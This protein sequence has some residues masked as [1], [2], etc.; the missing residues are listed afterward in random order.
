M[1]KY[2]YCQTWLTCLVVPSSSPGKIIE[3]Y[4]SQY[5]MWKK[6]SESIW[7]FANYIVWQKYSFPTATNYLCSFQDFMYSKSKKLCT[8]L[9]LFPVHLSQKK[10]DKWCSIYN[11]PPLPYSSMLL[12][13][14]DCYIIYVFENM[15]MCVFS[16]LFPFK[17]SLFQSVLK[18]K[19]HI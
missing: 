19:W 3:L 11:F 15:Y 17:F 6:Y 8:I 13:Y 14:Y 16:D 10:R 5:S 7:I 18:N 4:Y 1:I 9:S 12:L 2:I